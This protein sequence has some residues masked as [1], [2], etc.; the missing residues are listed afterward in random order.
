[1]EW[2]ETFREIVDVRLIETPFDVDRRFP[3]H[4]ARLDVTKT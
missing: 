1:M 3:G 4:F 2:P